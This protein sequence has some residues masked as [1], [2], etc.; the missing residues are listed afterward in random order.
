MA[1][2]DPAKRWAHSKPVTPIGPV[3]TFGFTVTITLVLMAVAPTIMP[4]DFAM[5][6]VSTM[7]LLLASMVALAGWRFGQT[8][9]DV[10]S[11]WDVA[12]AL[13]LFGIFAGILIEPEQVLRLME[14][15]QDGR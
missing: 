9:H 11:Y 5:P 8:H 10:L 12:G 2:T 7:F 13:T 14:G 4:R 15:Q 3:V 1:T 6:V